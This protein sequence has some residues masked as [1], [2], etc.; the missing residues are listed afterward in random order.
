MDFAQTPEWLATGLL[1]AALAAF[2]YVLKQIVEGFIAWDREQKHTNETRRTRLIALHSILRASK[3]VFDTQ[4]TLRNSLAEDIKLAESIPS[5]AEEGYAAAALRAQAGADGYEALFSRHYTQLTP[6][7]REL[8]AL[9]RSY[10]MHAIR[11]LN[12]AALEW[13]RA[14]TFYKSPAD[15]A[16]QVG[17]L[18]RQ[19]AQLEAHLI[20][21]FAKYE[22]WIPDQPHH[23]LVY[24]GDEQ[25]HGIGFP[26]GIERLIGDI[27]Q[28]N[29]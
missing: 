19:L 11:P 17:K 14:D 27:L 8:H 25:Q 29:G 2:G 24:L 22:T 21:W 15:P 18:A 12:Q 4:R 16:G 7:Q 5:Q 9:I 13:L 28:E 3:A 1:T 6:E 26:V 10:T 20:L 23:A